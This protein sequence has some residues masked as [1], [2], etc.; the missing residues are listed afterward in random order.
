MTILY[1]Y[2]TAAALQNIIGTKSLWT[3]DYRFLNDPTEF[4][5][6]WEIVL[7][8]L[9]SHEDDLKQISPPANYVIEQLR[10]HHDRKRAHA[11]VGSLTSQGDLLSQWRGYNGGRG[12]SIGFNEQWL[13]ENA[14]AQDFHLVRVVY[15]ADSQ[16]AAAEDV[17]NS[18]LTLTGHRCLRRLA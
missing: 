10:D 9:K 7:A 1:H 2:T 5:Y 3:S 13:Q 4:R 18:L 6:G 17:V 14:T 11:F 8:A 16:R 12:F 15:D